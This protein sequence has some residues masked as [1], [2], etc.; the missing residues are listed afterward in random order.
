[1][2]IVN[3]DNTNKINREDGRTI[4]DLCEQELGFNVHD[5]K[6]IFVEHPP[7]FTE[8]LHYHKESFEI[9]YFIDDARYEINGE[10]H[11]I[12]KGDLV[13]FEPNEVHGGL[14]TSNKVGLFIIQAPPIK[15]DK[16][17][18]EE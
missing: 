8:K 12:K 13:I 11:D 4:W 10:A 17:F 7:E 5:I 1:M 3:C 16:Y 14:P 9:F 18:P 15:G 2:R 6:F